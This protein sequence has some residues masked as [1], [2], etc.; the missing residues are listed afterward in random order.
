MLCAAKH[1]EV[2]HGVMNSAELGFELRN[3]IE[4]VIDQQFGFRL[5]PLTVAAAIASGH[6]KIILAKL[7][8]LS[9]LRRVFTSFDSMAF[10]VP[11]Q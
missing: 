4:L 9:Y 8:A 10:S 1:L 7:A 3:E 6:M 5:K 2:P 11:R